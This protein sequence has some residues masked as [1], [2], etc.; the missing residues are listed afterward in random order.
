MQY[1]LHGEEADDKAESIGFECRGGGRDRAT[2]LR[3]VVSRQASVETEQTHLPDEI[4]ERHNRTRDV[5]WCVERVCEIWLEG[6]ER[7]LVV[8]ANSLSLVQFLR[9]V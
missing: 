5:E 1:Q 8:H 2:E 3:G 7:C 9:V 4:V 6:V